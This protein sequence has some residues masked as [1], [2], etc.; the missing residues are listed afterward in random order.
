[1][2]VHAAMDAED[3]DANVDRDHLLE[4]HEIL[5]RLEDSESDAIADDIY[6]RLRFDLCAD[7]Y[8]K[9]AVNPIGADATALA[10]RFSQN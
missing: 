5:E 6:Q 3:D 9:F 4:V 8:R 7:C 2:E 10:L 1:M